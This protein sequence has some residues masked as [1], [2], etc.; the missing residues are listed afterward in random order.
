MQIDSI[1]LRA[2]E[3][4]ITII[5]KKTTHNQV[6]CLIFS[7]ATF[8][9]NWRPELLSPHKEMGSELALHKITIQ[10]GTL[11]DLVSIM[12]K[13]QDDTITYTLPFL[14]SFS[15]HCTENSFLFPWND[16]FDGYLPFGHHASCYTPL[17]LIF[18]TRR[19][20][21]LSIEFCTKTF[22]LEK[23]YDFPREVIFLYETHQ[24]A[25]G[26]LRPNDEGEPIE[27]NETKQ[28]IIG[29]TY[30]SWHSD[31]SWKDCNFTSETVCFGSG[32]GVAKGK[33]RLCTWMASFY[34]Q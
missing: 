34:K 28:K 24:K 10:N 20:C 27:W 31:I 32:M 2:T 25:I 19:E 7:D 30:M 8:R 18:C 15:I 11:C 23:L 29:S 12:F 1:R 33:Y 5:D 17:K 26:F 14:L 21:T 9:D 22:M 13:I 6:G 16:L 3:Q 4:I